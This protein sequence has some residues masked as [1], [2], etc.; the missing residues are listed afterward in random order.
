MSATDQ[1]PKSTEE[2]RS[3]VEAARLRLVG[4]VGELGRTIDETKADLKRRAKRVAPIV[5]GMVVAAIAL[6]LIVKHR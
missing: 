3:D 2:L 5:A 6:R 1:R 4:T